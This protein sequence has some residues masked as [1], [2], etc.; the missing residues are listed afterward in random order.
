M[1]AG[2]KIYGKSWF[3]VL[4]ELQISTAEIF[5]A[6]EKHRN[7]ITRTYEGMTT[8]FDILW[9]GLNNKLS[10]LWSF[11]SNKLSCKKLLMQRPQIQNSRTL[12]NQIKSK[13]KYNMPFESS[14][15]YILHI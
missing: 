15:L 11:S 14:D 1:L 9:C 13:P 5:V 6:V 7:G 10:T 3:P 8:L 4:F 12:A 2:W